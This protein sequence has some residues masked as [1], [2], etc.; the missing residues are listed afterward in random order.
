MNIRKLQLQNNINKMILTNKSTLE[1]FILKYKLQLDVPIPNLQLSNINIHDDYIS[2]CMSLSTCECKKIIDLTKHQDRK[3]LINDFC[4]NC[5]IYYKN[6][7]SIKLLINEIS[8]IKNTK[9]TILKD[10][11]NIT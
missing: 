7:N 4:N 5:P 8:L 10:I 2:N 9:N 6:E 1:H 3:C 11:I